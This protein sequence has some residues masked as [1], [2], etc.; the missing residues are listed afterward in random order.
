MDISLAA[1]VDR[2]NYEIRF[3]INL[4]FCSIY[5]LLILK[6]RLRMEPSVL[7][8]FF[9][10]GF[11]EGIEEFVPAYFSGTTN[12]LKKGAAKMSAA[13]KSKDGKKLYGKSRYP[14]HAQFCY[15]GRA[16]TAMAKSDEV[17]TLPRK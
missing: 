8:S 3:A 17:L 7:P 6:N 12:A 5:L 4:D 2:A 14:A 10:K 16:P 13:R 15:K 11:R 9:P 1:F